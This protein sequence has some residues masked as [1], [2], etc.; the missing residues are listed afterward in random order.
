VL[1]CSL[2]LTP[3]ETLHPSYVSRQDCSNREHSMLALASGLRG[4]SLGETCFSPLLHKQS[5][6]MDFLGSRAMQANAVY[7]AVH[8]PR[9][10][11]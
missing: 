3:R 11:L 8:L 2:F 10:W 6:S 7:L 9:A 5:Y 4:A 1:S